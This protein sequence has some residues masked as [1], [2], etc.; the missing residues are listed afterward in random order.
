MGRTGRSEDGTA[1][2]C[3]VQLPILFSE[4]LSEGRFV[5][6]MPIPSP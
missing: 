6:E 3:V 4:R 2:W 1:P 5:T